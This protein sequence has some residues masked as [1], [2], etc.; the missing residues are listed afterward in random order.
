MISRKLKSVTVEELQKS[1]ESH[2]RQFM[3]PR[4]EE[5]FSQFHQHLSDIRIPGAVAS[6]LR[7]LNMGELVAL[8]WLEAEPGHVTATHQDCKYEPDLPQRWHLP[9]RTDTTIFTE[10]GVKA[11]MWEGAWYGPVRY[12]LPHSVRHLDTVTR[13]H[14]MAD[15]E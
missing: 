15:F 5:G 11:S 8:V 13:V 2:I 7:D 6:A 3:E 14:L 1:Y 10:D 4:H 12:W 9:I